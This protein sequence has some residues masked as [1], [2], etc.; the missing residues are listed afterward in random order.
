MQG[1]LRLSSPRSS[2]ECLRFHSAT[3]T[4]PPVASPRQH[5]PPGTGS[6]SRPTQPCR[7]ERRRCLRH[8]KGC[9][10]LSWG[11][12]GRQS[13]LCLFAQSSLHPSCFLVMQASSLGPH[14]QGAR[15]ELPNPVPCPLGT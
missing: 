8:P 14:Q 1:K 7:E 6:L 13:R 10:F 12:S 2:S 5:I 11:I 4:P 3:S 15:A 9:R